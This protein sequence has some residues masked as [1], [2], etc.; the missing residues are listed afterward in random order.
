MNRI[1]KIGL[2]IFVLIIAIQFIQPARNKR[3]KVLPADISKIYNV[4]ENVQAILKK[5]C[6][7]CHSNN[8]NYPWYAKIQPAGW[9][10]ASHIKKGKE[11]LNFSEF[12][13]YSSFRQQS[14]FNAIYHSIEDGTM[15]LRSY[16]FIHRDSKL[17]KTEK[18]IIINWG[19]KEKDS[20][21]PKF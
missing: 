16:T 20:L 2:A 17:S 11:D 19:S 13:N 5:S 18:E 9:W 15:P 14:K 8:T 7:D 1:K 10:L 3:G 21:S 12:G 6:Y 4:P